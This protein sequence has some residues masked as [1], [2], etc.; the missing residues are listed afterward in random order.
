[1]TLLPQGF[2]Q[3]LPIVRSFVEL[4]LGKLKKLLAVPWNPGPARPARKKRLSASSGC[5]RQSMWR[6]IRRPLR[7]T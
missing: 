7:P 3:L 4:H 1:M 6:P 2:G 5:S